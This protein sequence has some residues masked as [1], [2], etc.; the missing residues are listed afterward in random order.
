MQKY[1]DNESAIK[2]PSLSYLALQLFKF[3]LTTIKHTPPVLKDDAE[4]RRTFND[5]AKTNELTSIGI[6]CGRILVKL[7]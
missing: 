5:L 4:R 7:E 1:E 2:L 3:Y 6:N